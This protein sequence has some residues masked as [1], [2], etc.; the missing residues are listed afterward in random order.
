VPFKLGIVISLSMIE[1]ECV[2]VSG[3][4]DSI[5]RPAAWPIGFEHPPD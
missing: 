2:R 5:Q 4:V 3:P 1:A